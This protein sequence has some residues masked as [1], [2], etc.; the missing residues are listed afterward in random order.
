MMVMQTQLCRH[1]GVVPI[2]RDY[3]IREQARL[4]TIESGRPV[5]LRPVGE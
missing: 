2:T 4:R 3:V 1:Q 5:T